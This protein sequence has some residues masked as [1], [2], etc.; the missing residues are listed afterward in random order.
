MKSKTTLLL[1]VL[2][3]LACIAIAGLLIDNKKLIVQLQEKD[4]RNVELLNSL[5]QTSKQLGDLMQKTGAHFI[6][7]Q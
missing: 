7:K 4:D 5:G 6:I 3:V 2:L 1:G